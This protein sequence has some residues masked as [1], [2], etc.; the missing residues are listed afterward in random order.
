MEKRGP[1]R[2]GHLALAKA[3]YDKGTMLMAGAHSDASG[4]TFVFSCDD[5]KPIKAFVA[6]DPYVKNGL[7]IG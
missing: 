7:V 2:P 1:H 5:E 6:A 3:A 4:A